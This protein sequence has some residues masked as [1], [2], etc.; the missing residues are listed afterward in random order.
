MIVR[1]SS[2]F[3]C[4]TLLGLAAGGCG[5]G[6]ASTADSGSATAEQP[7]ASTQPAATDTGAPAASVQST[8]TPSPTAME[9][10]G[11]APTTTAAG[12]GASG[13]DPVS[14]GAVAAY[15][16]YLKKQAASLVKRTT[17]L[18]TALQKGN[19]Q[20]AVHLYPHGRA[21]YERI[22][23]VSGRVREGLG[24][25]IAA[26]EG[27][28]PA[29]QWAGFH[30]IEKILFD[31]GTTVDT[32]KPGRE[33]VADV[34]ELQRGV[35]G[36]QLDPGSIAAVALALVG[37][38]SGAPLDGKEERWSHTD[39]TDV[40][41]NIAGAGAAW[42]AVRPIVATRDPKLV[43]AV[44]RTHKQARLIV[45]SFKVRGSYRHYDELGTNE[46]AVIRGKLRALQ[47]QLE[48]VPPLLGA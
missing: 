23:P 29:G 32:E 7:S 20:R 4:C 17:E 33:L 16:L 14:A 30:K 37:D 25:E 22:S 28:V 21:L 41:A 40:A 18:S 48:K 19:P 9:Q 12:G 39:I 27:D 13:S 11:S 45:E 47:A 10:G 26:L 34:T 42:E 3:A 46:I 6:T 31:T 24:A 8:S 2:L 38:A 5:G 43:A 15:D 1:V 35:D 44:N 36:L